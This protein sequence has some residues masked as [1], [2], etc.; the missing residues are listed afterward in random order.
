MR[1]EWEGFYLDGQTAERQSVA[2]R[3]MRSGL[4]VVT[5]RGQTLW[6]PYAEI[7]QTQGFY[8]GE[9]V[10]LERGGELSEAILIAD[11]A[12][13][14]ALHAV[15]PEVTAHFH[16]PSRRR[17]RLQ[18]T[19]LAALATVLVTTALY[20]WGI[21]ALATLAAAR[22]PVAWEEQLGRTVVSQLAPPDQRCLDPH[23]A[24]ALDRIVA[25]LSGPVATN[26][27]TFRVTVLN[28]PAVNAFAVPG[29]YIVLMRGLLE[30]VRTPEELAGVLAHEMQHI[31]QRH[32]TRAI[33]QHASTG[34]LVTALSGD[35]SGLMAYGLET[36]RHLGTLRHS[37][38]SEAEADA[39][40]TRMLLAAGVDP[41]GVVT[42]LESLAKMEPEAPEVLTYLSTHPSNATRIARLREL[43]AT[44]R[45]PVALLDETEWRA[46]LTMCE[47][48]GRSG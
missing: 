21:P 8:A 32:P 33:L 22:V 31:L 35:V 15:A 28:V 14:R 45:N 46:I 41:A 2:V 36:A 37:R 23:G 18:L 3:L 48:A 24:R 17:L 34:L 38:R 16:D 27:Y 4:E 39:E 29:G 9:H 19:I 30:H 42:F 12:F 13:L 1:T 44:P 5:P 20:L 40:G 7:R 25:T 26:P 10:R 43:A 11:A 47:P 6:W